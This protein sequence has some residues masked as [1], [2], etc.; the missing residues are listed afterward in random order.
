MQSLTTIKFLC[1]QSFCIFFVVKKPLIVSLLLTSYK[2]QNK[3]VIQKTD[4]N[5]ISINQILMGD[6][7]ANLIVSD[8]KPIIK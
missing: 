2:K 5:Q 7:I 8:Y 6:T 3:N 4:K 1:Y